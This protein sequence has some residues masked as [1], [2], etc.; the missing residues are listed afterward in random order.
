MAVIWAALPLRHS[1]DAIR[2][3]VWRKP[4]PGAEARHLARERSVPQSGLSNMSMP[5][6][7]NRP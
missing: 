3:A 1:Y 4:V 7:Q 5:N 6:S 2:P